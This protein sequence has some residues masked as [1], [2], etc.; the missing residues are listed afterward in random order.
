[1]LSTNEVRAR[2]ARFADEWKDA[3]Y[4]KGETQSFYN[5]FFEV[6]GV[7]RRQVAR[8]EEPV[9]LLGDRRG[10][11]D[12]FWKGVL[13][14]E[15]KSAGKNLRAARSQ[16]LDYFPGLKPAELPRYLLL[17]DFQTFELINLDTRSETKLALRDLH[18]HVEA[19]DFIRGREKRE[20]KDQD[21]VNVDASELMGELH[22]ALE[23]SGYRGHDLERFLVR[24]VFCLFADDTGIFDPR[25][26]FVGLIES[27][28]Q[29]DGSDTG[30]WLAQLFDVLNTPES[31][32][33]KHLDEDL[34]AFQFIN[35]DL[36]AERL[37][38]PSFDSS[39]RALLIKACQFDWAA[40]SPA[41]FG[42]LF[43]SVM[44]KEE[45]RK[46]GAHYT[47]EKNIL[48]VIGPLFLDAL[49]AEFEQLKA[50]RDSRR[51]TTLADFHDRLRRLRLLDPAC[52]CGNFLII[53]YRELR[54]LEIELLR[55]IHK[56]E[57]KLYLDVSLLSKLDVDQFFGIELEEFSARI[58]EVALWMMDH[59][60]N[61]ELSRAFGQAYA[62]IPLKKAPHIVH[63]D[64]LE[65]DWN[66]ILPASECSFVLGNP[67]FVGAK[68]QSDAQRE[69]VRRIARLGGTG[70][71]LDYVTA[72][73][74]RAGEYIQAAPTSIG[75]V[76]T[77]S[78]T[79][80]EQVAQ[81]WPLLFDRYGLEIDFA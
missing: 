29:E 79:Q 54:R 31:E 59:I 40:I 18:K 74:L 43:Q 39:M 22:D 53:A 76:A 78:I 11:L 38:M 14:V 57:E 68:Y 48:K 63:A 44:N 52:G 27:R 9:R 30:Q 7:K 51:R 33:Q 72:W 35:G 32:R 62:R 13:L 66:T 61:N 75:F 36:F 64:A 2:A 42:A 50:R 37:R 70:G 23:E 65:T 41:I 20:Y 46:K 1:M 73:F 45:R 24:L 16:A 81:L 3:E 49:R 10:F 58:A 4:E 15:Q 56:G 34:K 25:D 28:T 55:E 6:F 67:P 5:D 12:L 21:P 71:T 77:N 17:S 80:G 19:F 8:F 26:M 47:S 69:Q 60:M